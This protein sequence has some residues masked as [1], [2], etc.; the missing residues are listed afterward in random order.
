[1]AD[2]AYVKGSFVEMNDA[3]VSIKD[4]GLL[5][6]DGVYEVAGV[7]EG[8]L[9]DNDAHLERLKRSLQEIKLELPMNFSELAGLQRELIHLNKIKEGTLY[10]HV[11]RGVSESR[12]FEFPKDQQPS[13][14]MFTQHKKIMNLET[15]KLKAKVLTYPDLRWKRRDI[16][17]IAL[18]AQVLAQEIAYQAGCDEVWMH[19][20]GFVTEGGSSNAFIIK[21]NKLISRKNNETILSGI[22]RQA[23]LKLIEQEDLVFEER[24]FT[25]EEAYEAS[26]A[27]YTSAS[28]FVMPVISIDKKIIG[29]GE[30]GVLT[31]KL[32]NLDENFAK[33]F[34]NQSQ[35]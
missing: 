9:I 6:G 18:L 21:D 10:L 25:I 27:F 13:L 32:R 30:P 26:E 12:D 29:N 15:D 33:S 22:T 35:R 3:T 23:V 8:I 14:V 16:K 19:E 1:M 24:P 11:T 4:R 20:D 5:F 2:I 31:L 28:V 17:S 7:F 34:I